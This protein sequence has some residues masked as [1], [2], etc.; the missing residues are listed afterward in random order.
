MTLLNKNKIPSLKIIF[1]SIIIFILCLQ[2]LSFSSP[3]LDQ[4]NIFHRFDKV[5]SLENWNLPY[6]VKVDIDGDGKKDNVTFYRCVFLSSADAKNI[7]PN[8]ICSD[9]LIG[10]GKAKGYQVDPSS[11]QKLIN[12]YL[13]RKHTAWQIVVN[14]LGNTKLYEINPDGTIQEKETPLSLRI[15]S[16]IYLLA[17]LF[18]LVI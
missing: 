1:I 11:S 5:Y 16:S 9:K 15:D 3:S 4:F 14:R 10:N 13:G 6:N 12:S 2:I 8:N 17:H 7:P 18:T